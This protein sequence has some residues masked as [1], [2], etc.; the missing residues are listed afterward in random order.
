[1][2]LV[3]PE[4]HFLSG[5]RDPEEHA[6]VGPADLRADTDLPGC[7]TMSWMVICTFGMP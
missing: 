4:A 3:Q 6:L 5:G 1:M 7:C 2:E